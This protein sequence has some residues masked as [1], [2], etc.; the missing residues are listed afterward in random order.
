MYARLREEGQRRLARSPLELA[1]TSF[2][3]GFDVVAGI[4]AMA[5]VQ[6][7]HGHVAG[8]IAFGIAFVFIVVGS[9]EL[10]TENF[11]VPIAGLDRHSRRDWFKLGELW[12]LS[13]IL[14]VG[15]GAILVYILSSHGVLP[16]GTGEELIEIA[17]KVDD[18]SALTS[19]LSAIVAG[20]LITIM[21]WMVE[22][23]REMLV[24]IV[25]AWIA[26]ALVALAA[27]DHVVV[28]TLEMIF[29]IRYGS[30]IGWG[31]VASNFGV[32][33]VGNLIGGVLLV[34]V[35]RTGQAHGANSD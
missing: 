26:G 34:T 12:T 3:A 1:S 14:N 13:P 16:E 30:D 9:S 18:N 32:A 27:L 6:H 35:T 24:R 29:A 7:H 21:T 11:F 20:A 8:S 4:V 25:C 23:M 33:A 17:E 28:V 10:F 2:V 22:G 31:D 19:F 15:G 5:I